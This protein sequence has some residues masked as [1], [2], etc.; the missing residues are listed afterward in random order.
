MAI[1]YD[2]RVSQ[3]TFEKMLRLLG[4]RRMLRTPITTT[5]QVFL[6][7]RIFF[8]FRVFIL[9]KFVAS[10]SPFSLCIYLI[11]DFWNARGYHFSFSVSSLSQF[12]PSNFWK[13]IYND[14]LSFPCLS[15]MKSFF[16]CISLSLSLC[17]THLYYLSFSLCLFVRYLLP[18]ASIFFQLCDH[19]WRRK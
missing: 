7:L 18:S 9:Q 10:S 16:L 4:S 12:N 15:S 1:F 3:G 6:L 19:R 14:S 8:S 13:T 17:L 11:H 2:H 5:T